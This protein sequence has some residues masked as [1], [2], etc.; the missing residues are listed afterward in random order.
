MKVDALV[1]GLSNRKLAL[2]LQTLLLDHGIQDAELRLHQQRIWI[3]VGFADIYVK[4]DIIYVARYGHEDV[5]VRDPYGPAS[6]D[7]ALEAYNDLIQH[8]GI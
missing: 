2:E 3:D 8:Y 4:G 7:T 1:E 5:A 6:Y